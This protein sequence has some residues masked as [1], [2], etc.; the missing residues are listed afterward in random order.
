MVTLDQVIRN[1]YIR[2][3][4]TT[5]HGYLRCMKFLID[6]LREIAL[7]HSVFDETIAL[8]MDQKKAVQ[9]PE[10]FIMWSKIG[11]QV[12]DRIVGFERDN[13]INL[14]HEIS[15]DGLESPVAN[16]KFNIGKFP[17]TR[18]VFHNFTNNEGELGFLEGMGLGH[19]GVGYFRLNWQA[20][21]IQFASDIDAD[22]VI[23]LEFK[24]NGFK[25][26]TKSTVPEIMS[27]LA[28]DYIHWQIGKQKFGDNS[29]E[30]GARERTYFNEYD[31]VIAAMNPIT[32][33]FFQGLRARNFDVTKLVY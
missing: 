26:T 28:E 19:N 33:A 1:Y 9:W 17:Y 32:M 24:T 20:R 4:K 5:L 13:T 27:K 30:A 23:Y 29:A 3:N 11:F 22:T 16:N 18:L 15:A 6:F 7:S 25:P 14:N 21:E 10:R 12:G 8:K 2:E 31:K